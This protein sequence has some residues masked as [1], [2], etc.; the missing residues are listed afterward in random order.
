[1]KI[2]IS[3][4]QIKNSNAVTKKTQKDK[5]NKKVSNKYFNIHNINF[6]STTVKDRV[7]F[8]NTKLKIALSPKNNCT[9]ENRHDSYKYDQNLANHLITDLYQ[10]KKLY[11]SDIPEQ[12]S[13]QPEAISPTL[14]LFFDLKEIGVSQSNINRILFFTGSKTFNDAC[15]YLFTDEYKFNHKYVSYQNI[16]YSW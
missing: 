1:M 10:S 2:S 16:C 4:I 13:Q 6:F 9:N 11:S 5:N 3:E 14:K 15:K 8:H 7:A 12:Y